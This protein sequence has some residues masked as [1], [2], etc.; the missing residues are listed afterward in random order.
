MGTTVELE[1][2]ATDRTYTGQGVARLAR[3][4]QEALGVL[5]GDLVA[6][7]GEA[8]AVARVWPAAEDA[9]DR[10][11]AIDADTQVN[12]G[13]AVGERVTVTP[14]TAVGATSVVVQPPGDV[15][16]GDPERAAT[17]LGRLLEDRPVRLG[18]EIHLE[19]VSDRPFTI[20]A[21]EPDGAVIITAATTL[22]LD[23]PST[24]GPIGTAGGVGYDAIGGLDRELAAVR[25]LVELPLR[26]PAMFAELGIDPPA[27]VLMHGPPGTG[28]TL[29]ARA[30]AHEADATFIHINGPEVVSKYK[31]ESEQQLRER[32]ETAARQA[33]TVLF[34]DEI[35]SIASSREDGGDLENR[36]VGQLLALMDGLVERGEVVVLAATNRVDAVDPALRRGGRFDREIEIGVPNAQGR[37]EILEVHTQRMPLGEDVDLDA[38][39]AQTHGF[40]G[41]DLRALTTEAAMTALRR[42]LDAA[43]DVAPTVTAAD[44]AAARAQ[45]DPSAMRAY[46]AEQPTETF[47]DVGGYGSVKQRLTEVVTWPL[48]AGA[49]F[50]AAG[51]GPPSG[52][53]LYGPPGTGKTLL[54]RAAAGESGVNF[55]PIA[56]PELLD[57]YVG[58]SEEAL[59]EV[60]TKAR[61]TAPTIIFFDELD[62]LVSDAGSSGVGGRVRAQLVTELDRIADHPG[63]VVI[64][65]TNRR[66]ALDAAL[67]RPGRFE[68]QERVGPPTA[69]DRVEIL[70]V[71]ARGMPLAADVDL[72]AIAAATEEATGAELQALLRRAA[73]TAVDALIATHGMEGAVERRR[74]L[75][76][77][78]EQLLAAGR[79]GG[80]EED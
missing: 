55:I 53:L 31:G 38:I 35:D 32:F 22:Q 61:Q 23:S 34:F 68:L 64:G 36:L 54:A 50:D 6:I 42:Q 66:D 28:K 17:L 12:A 33:P 14:T 67:L 3:D 70:R 43:A 8:T 5:S 76:I 41:A 58:A 30:V 40:V 59:R 10:T 24:T 57:R 56:G 46:V 45:V 1:V 11:I 2:T 37:R 15:R 18:E 25:E 29:I 49:L 72:D 52:V 16:F 71:L 74:E 7:T 21:T 48:Q 20:T 80:V 19:R 75:A 62:A 63:L 60:F 9:A 65:A 4:A 13:A 39:A 69:A 78:Q 27:G 26:D 47:A 44:F 51:V 73:L 79:S 77:T